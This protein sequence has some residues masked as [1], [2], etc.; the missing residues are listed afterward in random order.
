MSLIEAVS[1]GGAVQKL[2]KGAVMRVDP[3][4]EGRLW[5]FTKGGE[6][7]ATVLVRNDATSAYMYRDE[8]SLAT[9]QRQLYT[10]ADTANCLN[11]LPTGFEAVEEWHAAV[12]RKL[13]LT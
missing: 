13:G 11:R 12:C 7:V 9:I 5:T 1:I 10:W 6:Q 4:P 3:H 2:V 8:E